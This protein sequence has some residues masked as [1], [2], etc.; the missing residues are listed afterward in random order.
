LAVQK[1]YINTTSFGIVDY[2]TYLPNTDYTEVDDRMA[3]DDDLTMEKKD[4]LAYNTS[5]HAARLSK[6]D[7]GSVNEESSVTI[8]VLATAIGSFIAG[9]AVT[10]AMMT[11]QRDRSDAEWTRISDNNVIQSSYSG[12]F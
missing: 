1:G 5:R 12:K 2:C 4:Y 10:Y 11:R 7:G 8:T 9:V 6:S 3:D